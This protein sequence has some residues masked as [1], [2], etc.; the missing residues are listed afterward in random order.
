MYEIKIRILYIIISIV[1]VKIKNKINKKKKKE[2]KNFLLFEIIKVY[3][4]FVV[5]YVYNLVL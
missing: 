4:R 2:W 1:V 5:S 3:F